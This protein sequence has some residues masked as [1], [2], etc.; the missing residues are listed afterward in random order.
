MLFEIYVHL[1]HQEF[2][3]ARTHLN[4]SLKFKWTKDIQLNVFP[5]KF[6]IIKIG[7]IIPSDYPW[8]GVYHGGC[9]IDIEAIADSGYNSLIGIII[10]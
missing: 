8:N 7:T 9:P 3:P 4:Q 6:G 2:L 5:S 1:T 10:I